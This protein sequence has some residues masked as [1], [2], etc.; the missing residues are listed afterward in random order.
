MLR[1]E[2]IL[3]ATYPAYETVKPFLYTEEGL[4]VQE[5][6]A[7][8]DLMDFVFNENGYDRM[9]SECPEFPIYESMITHFGFYVSDY[10]DIDAYR[11]ELNRTL[12]NLNMTDTELTES[13]ELFPSSRKTIEYLFLLLNRRDIIKG[14]LIKTM[15]LHASA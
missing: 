13:D 15:Q 10:L 6:I 11:G 9:H 3:D 12:V 2:N 4:K 1:E 8:V 14:T 7:T 5:H